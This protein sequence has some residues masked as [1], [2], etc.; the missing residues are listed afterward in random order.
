MNTSLS[1]VFCLLALLIVTPG[2]AETNVV[3]LLPLTG[4][5]AEFGTA[6]KAGIQMAAEGKNVRFL[7]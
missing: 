5:Q 3:A 7:F 2:Q 1:F 6:V 4:G